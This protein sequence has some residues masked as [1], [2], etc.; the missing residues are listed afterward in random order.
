MSV[1]FTFLYDKIGCS[2]SCYN[3]NLKF[4]CSCDVIVTSSCLF[5]HVSPIRD[6]YWVI[7]GSPGGGKG[8]T[9]KGGNYRGKCQ[10]RWSISG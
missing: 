1:E 10:L 3:G 2:Q 5:G 4:L 8:N 7:F 9:Q 6:P